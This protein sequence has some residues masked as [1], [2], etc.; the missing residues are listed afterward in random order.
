M[1]G[2]MQRFHHQTFAAAALADSKGRRRVSVCLPARNEQQTVGP[3]VET[4]RMRLMEAAPLVDELLVIDD[5]STDSTAET[6]LAAG[7]KV[8]EADAVR[9]EL[10]PGTGKGE[11]M[12]KGLLASTGDVVVFCD[13][14][15]R[16]FDPAF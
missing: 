2:A 4:I 13:A 5:G 8:V 6:A 1:E 12:W 16:N 9:P 10:G 11:A 14:D 7:A 3:I 15:V